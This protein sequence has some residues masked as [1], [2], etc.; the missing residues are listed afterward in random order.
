MRMKQGGGNLLTQKPKAGDTGQPYEDEDI[1]PWTRERTSKAN[2]F[3]G[4]RLWMRRSGESEEGRGGWAV[5]LRSLG[6]LLQYRF[7]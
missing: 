2:G 3:R 4:A 7:P 1:E 6:L 5:R